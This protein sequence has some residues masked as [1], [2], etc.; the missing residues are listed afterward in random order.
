MFRSTFRVFDQRN[1]VEKS[2]SKQRGFLDH[3][4]Y[5]EKSTWKQ[6]GYFD[7]HNC[8]EKSTWKQHVFFDHRN[9]TERSTLKRCGFLDHQNYIEKKKHG[10]DVDFSISKITSKKYV[11]M[12]WNSSKFG[13]RHI[14]V[15]STWNRR[16]FDVVCSLGCFL[17]DDK[18]LHSI[19]KHWNDG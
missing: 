12:T 5:I 1:Y 17:N 9:Y 19:S 18:S 6:H 2:A 7:Q 13:L 10:S 8:I 4:Y 14:N 15:L 3:W 11:Q 16:W